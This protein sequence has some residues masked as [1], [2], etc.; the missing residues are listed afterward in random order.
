MKANE[1]FPF[2][3]LARS[4]TGFQDEIKTRR[5]TLVSQFIIGYR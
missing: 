5:F 2:I 1:Y 4:V 3:T